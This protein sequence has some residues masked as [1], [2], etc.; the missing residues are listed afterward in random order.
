VYADLPSVAEV[1][2]QAV[3]AGYELLLNAPT[4]DEDAKFR[5]LIAIGTFA[6]AAGDT[7]TLAKDLGLDDV[8]E[9]M[10]A[11]G[12]KVADAAA[13]LKTVLSR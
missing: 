7:K 5:C 9:T 10:R 6:N 8:A 2:A 3:S 1:A 4:E 11:E 12:G 13:D